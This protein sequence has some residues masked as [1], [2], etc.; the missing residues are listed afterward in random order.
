MP[1][2][3][4]LASCLTLLTV[5]PA[6]Q[7]AEA[8]PA[9][10]EDALPVAVA[11]VRPQ[12]RYVVTRRFTGVVRSRRDAR[13]GFERGGLVAKVKVDD[14]DAVKHG[15]VIAHLDVRSLV[16]ERRQLVAKLA[17]AEAGVSIARLTSGRLDRLAE[18]RFASR[19]QRD[20]A[21][22]QLEAARAQREQ[23][24]A[25]I[26][27][28]DVAIDKSVLRAPFAGTVSKRLVDEGTV[29][30]AGTPVVRFLDQGRSEAVIGVPV[31]V[32]PEIAV[33]SRREVEVAEDVVEGEIVAHV[34]DVDPRTRTVDVIVSLPETVDAVDGAIVRLR[35]R[36]D[37]EGRGVWLPRQT[38]T[39][40]LPGLFSAYAVEGGR[41]VRHDVEI[42]HLEDDQVFA[43]STLEAGAVVVVAGTHRLVQHQRVRRVDASEAQR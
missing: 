11:E 22:F 13:L 33:G 35:H 17:E 4:R 14:G 21:S 28:L 6:C 18:E 5:A 43:R 26:A 20:E 30:A 9:S 1:Y 38:L 3:F 40:G 32:A 31:A 42:L 36:R 39:E 7:P 2:A 41:A 12:D 25:A 19:Q 16:A 8:G 24:R 37:V 27:A 15:Q 10:R 29:V 34:R 23:L